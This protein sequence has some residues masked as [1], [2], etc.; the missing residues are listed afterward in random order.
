MNKKLLIIGG[1]AVILLL[2]FMLPRAFE[3]EEK[4]ELVVPVKRGHFEASITTT[5]ELQ[6]ENSTEIKGPQSLRRAGI[7][8]VPITD[9]VPEGTK[10]VEGDYVA[11][12]DRT[13]AS[14]KLK[15]LFGE[16]KKYESQHTQTKIDTTLELKDAY[17]QLINLSYEKEEAKITLDQ[18]QFEP[19][20][21]IRQAEIA[22][23]RLEF[24]RHLPSL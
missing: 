21:I 14:N 17:E 5:G 12:L 11:T 15:E 16:M 1:L 4:Q 3:Q 9:L 23:D 18:S 10:V 6:A 24:A 22:N 13:E 2:A 19:P 20:A 7:W 8:R